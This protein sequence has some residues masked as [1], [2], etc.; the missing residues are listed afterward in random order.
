MSSYKRDLI[1]QVRQLIKGGIIR[2]PKWFEAACRV[3][4]AGTP[5]R[6]KKVE[7]IRLPEDPLVTSFYARHPEARFTPYKLNSFE[8]PIARRFAWRQMELMREGY[9]QREARDQVELE[10]E[11]QKRREQ[12]EYEAKRLRAIRMGLEVP[13][14][15]KTILEEVQEEERRAIIEGFRKQ[16][17]VHVRGFDV[18]RQTSK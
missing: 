13:P 15:K 3:P 10:F 14:R 4:P 12:K 9:S 17:E 18:M 16:T 8:P 11:E 1:S 5:R 2:K 7:K 6:V